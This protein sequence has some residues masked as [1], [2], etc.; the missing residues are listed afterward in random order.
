MKTIRNLIALAALA[1]LS[2]VPAFSQATTFQTS[3]TSPITTQFQRVITVASVGSSTLG[4][5]A[6]NLG[7][8]AFGQAPSVQILVDSELMDVETVAGTTITVRRGAGG[9]RAQTH[10]SGAVVFSGQPNIVFFNQ[11]FYGSCLLTTGVAGTP[12]QPLVPLSLPIWVIMPYDGLVFQQNCVNNKWVTVQGPGPINAP[13]SQF[14]VGAAYTNAT[15]SFTNVTGLT[16]FPVQA[17]TSMKLSCD[18]YWQGS[19]TTAGPKYQFTG[20]AS[21]TAVIA[22]ATS[23]VTASTF[24]QSVVTAFSTPMANAGTITAT[25]NFHDIVTL[26]LNNG[27]NAGVVSLQAAANGAGTLTIQPG[28]V[29]TQQ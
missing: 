28:S 23:E 12:G 3:L 9:T 20:P 5:F 14:V 17:N 18:I 16:G 21:P 22:Q 25:T 10:A 11:P 29:C 2:A 13:V 24:T 8:A 1:A 15:T 7:A 19:T 4:I 27:A 26:S 6:P